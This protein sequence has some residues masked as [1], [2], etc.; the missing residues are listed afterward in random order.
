MV[1]ILTLHSLATALVGIPAVGAAN[2]ML[3]QNICDIVFCD[4][5]AHLWT[6]A[7]YCGLLLSPAQGAPVF[8]IMLFNQL[9]DMPHLSGG[10]IILAK[11]KF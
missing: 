1:E 10:W 11:E 9:L 3:L 6:V 4:K 5:T 7:C 8:I 2:C